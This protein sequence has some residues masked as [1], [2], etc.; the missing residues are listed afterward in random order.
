[1]QKLFHH[2]IFIFQTDFPECLPAFE[3]RMAVKQQTSELHKLAWQISFKKAIKL[4]MRLNII[5]SPKSTGQKQQ[6]S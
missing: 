6:K 3:L 2:V 5:S 4:K 1:M